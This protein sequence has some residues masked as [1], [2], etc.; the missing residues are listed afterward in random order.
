MIRTYLFISF[1]QYMQK[2]LCMTVMTTMAPGVTCEDTIMVVL[3]LSQNC[4]AVTVPLSVQATAVPI[5]IKQGCD[6]LE[7]MKTRAPKLEMC[8]FLVEIMKMKEF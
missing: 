1:P 6:A 7:I 3:V 8:D 5:L 2:K 4:P